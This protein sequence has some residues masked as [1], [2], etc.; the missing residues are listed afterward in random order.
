MQFSK[1][2]PEDIQKLKA[3]ISSLNKMLIA[4]PVAASIFYGI[5]MTMFSFKFFATE[6]VVFASFCL[7]FVLIAC[8]AVLVRKNKMANDLAAG[9]KT[10]VEDE[11]ASK[12]SK[13]NDSY[14]SFVVKGR[15]YYVDNEIY[16]RF[17]RGDRVRI[18]L[19]PKSG[20]VFGVTK[21]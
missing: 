19:A 3:E 17:D 15:R 2:T 6:N 18:E 1:A 21:V 14:G 5:G 13:R 16:H 8:T 9:A 7:I 11:I 10:F 4:V 20:F 12:Y